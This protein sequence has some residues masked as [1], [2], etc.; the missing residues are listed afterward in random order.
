[1]LIDSTRLLLIETLHGPYPDEV[2]QAFH[3][4]ARFIPEHH[5][6]LLA[7][8]QT[9]YCLIGKDQ[10]LIGSGALDL[11]INPLQPT[12]PKLLELADR[13]PRTEEALSPYSRGRNVHPSVVLSDLIG[14]PSKYRLSGCMTGPSSS[15]Q[16]DNFVSTFKFQKGSSIYQ[17]FLKE[18]KQYNRVLPEFAKVAD[19]HAWR[20]QIPKNRIILYPS[21]CEV[22]R[23]YPEQPPSKERVLVDPQIPKRAREWYE[24]ES[25]GGFYAP[26]NNKVV[27]ETELV[28]VKAKNDQANLDAQID[29]TKLCG[30]RLIVHESGHALRELLGSTM[31]IRLEEACVAAMK[32]IAQHAGLGCFFPE[33][34]REQILN[35]CIDELIA[36]TY[37][38]VHSESPDVQE[39]LQLYDPD[40][41]KVYCETIETLGV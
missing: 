15:T 30:S 11:V 4:N 31:A 13:I 24:G 20:V 14:R 39:R 34:V 38:W 21:C 36:L 27:L 7:A 37:E 35:S 3:D 5:Q 28:V 9:E 17:W 8:N 29:R 22:Y 32:K 6:R 2:R 10:S 1:M 25:G 41:W 33:N 23:N 16:L 19:R 12:D 18:T 26:L 40:Y